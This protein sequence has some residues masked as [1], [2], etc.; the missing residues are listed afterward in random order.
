MKKIFV[1]LFTAI[2]AVSCL[3]SNQ[4]HTTVTIKENQFFINGEL[5]YPGRYWQGKK[6]EGLILNSRMVQGVF[7]DLNPGTRKLFVY[8]D[9]REWDAERNTNEFVDAM[10]EWY[11]HG[12]IAFTI[13]L[14]GGSPMGYGNK[15]WYNSAFNEKGDL[16]K[17]YFGRL[18]KIL[19]RADEL[20]MVV[21]LG[22]FY[23][24][25]DQHLENEQAIINAVHKATEWLFSKGYKNVIIEINNEC[26]ISDYDHDILKSARVH[27]LIRLVKEMNRDHFSYLVGT[28]YSGGT[29]PDSNVVNASDFILLHGNGVDNPHRITEMVEQTKRIQG[30]RHQPIVFNE[31]DHYFFDRRENNFVAAVRAYASWGYFDYRREGESFGEGFQSVPVDWRI[32]SGRKRA[33]FQKVKEITGK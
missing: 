7:D 16:R 20:G 14:Q 30:Y 2:M 31:D 27:E 25:Q 6:I 22:Y 29:I 10:D 1:I 18:E 21:I 5:T 15:N 32:H 19:D 23:F 26:D 13:N 11:D 24:G 33:F 3:E 4:R 12:M 17:E 9:T 8:P 28:S